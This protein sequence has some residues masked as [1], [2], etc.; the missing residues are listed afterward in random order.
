MTSPDCVTPLPSHHDTS[1]ACVT[2]L[3]LYRRV[4]LPCA[5]PPCHLS[6]CHITSVRDDVIILTSSR[7]I[8][9]LTSPVIQS[10]VMLMSSALFWR[11]GENRTSEPWNQFLRQFFTR[12]FRPKWGIFR[13]SFHFAAPRKPK[14][15]RMNHFSSRST[16]KGAENNFEGN[17]GRTTAVNL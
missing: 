15:C 13:E 14:R 8:I 10:P 3:P 17:K 12:F 6:Y 1:L 11:E 7:Y 16:Q 5:L 2:L 4:T 9:L